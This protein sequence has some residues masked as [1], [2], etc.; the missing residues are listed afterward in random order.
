MKPV[1]NG[2][3]ALWALLRAAGRLISAPFKRIAS[4]QLPALPPRADAVVPEPRRLAFRQI[5]RSVGRTLLWVFAVVAFVGTQAAIGYKIFDLPN[6]FLFLVMGFAILTALVLS[7]GSRHW[8]VLLF[9]GMLTIMTGQLGQFFGSSKLSTFVFESVISVLF[10]VGVVVDSISIRRKTFPPA[11]MLIVMA[12]YISMV[13]TSILVQESLTDYRSNRTRVVQVFLGLAF[14]LGGYIYFERWEQIRTFLRFMLGGAFAFGLLAL[15]EYIFPAPLYYNVYLKLFPSIGRR[16]GRALVEHR[17][18]G[19]FDNPIVFGAWLGMF[20]P[21]AIYSALYAKTPRRRFWSWAGVFLL[22]VAVFCTG[23]RGPFLACV[24]AVA[25][26]PWLSGRRRQAIVTLATVVAGVFYVM[27]VG[28]QI[29]KLLPAN[30]LVTRFVDPAGSVYSGKTALSTM[31][32]ARF[33]SWRD[34]INIWRQHPWFG[35]GAGDWVEYRR[36][37]VSTRTLTI[38]SSY[39]PYLE[40]LAETGV[41]GFA[42]LMLLLWIT[43]VYDIRA[44]RATPPGSRQAWVAALICSGVVIHIA[45][46][47]DSPFGLNRV[48]YFF[49]LCQ[50]ILLKTPHVARTE[51]EPEPEAAAALAG[52]LRRA[53]APSIP[54]PVAGA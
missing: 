42:S 33:E 53:P 24:I 25:L 8:R 37:S 28:P 36:R 31:E 34:A 35:I 47:P 13:V 39:S 54:E 1:R 41:F 3:A 21:L 49:W 30:N 19:P 7:G 2:F 46:I 27:F 12:L 11:A 29:A 32:N 38:V 26:F 40:A 44:W 52:G 14:F 17:V 18:F 22:A 43:F 20:L 51:L 50:G 48:Y 5:L 45:S 15:V 9:V 6:V 23:S 16:V 10:T 4:A